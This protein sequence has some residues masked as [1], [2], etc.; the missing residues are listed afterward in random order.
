MGAAGGGR[1]HPSIGHRSPQNP[2][3]SGPGHGKRPK[4][5]QSAP[6]LIER[7]AGTGFGSRQARNHWLVGRRQSPGPH[8][9]R[10]S[11]ACREPTGQ[12]KHG[13]A[14]QPGSRL[15]FQLLS[16]FGRE[17]SRADDRRSPS[18]SQ[19]PSVQAGGAGIQETSGW[20]RG[21]CV[22]GSKGDIEKDPAIAEAGRCTGRGGSIGRPC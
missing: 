4:L 7:F 8:G 16:E 2:S 12:I 15:L 18:F 22:G 21:A 20:S 1:S 5:G 3:G 17:G 14:E 11:G 10:Q 13:A 6:G 19:G 9:A